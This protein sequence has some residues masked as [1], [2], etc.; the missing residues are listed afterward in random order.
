MNIN[1]KSREEKMNEDG[2]DSLFNLSLS[3]FSSDTSFLY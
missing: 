3:D 1:T 2:A